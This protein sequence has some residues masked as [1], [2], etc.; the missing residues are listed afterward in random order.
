MLAITSCETA[1]KDLEWG[2]SRLYMPQATSGFYSVPLAGDPANQNYELD[3]LANTLEIYL[4]VYRSGSE[5][6]SSATAFIITETDT[7]NQLIAEGVISN[8]IL[9]PSDTYELPDKV[10]ISSGQQS[11]AFRLS[12]DLVKLNENYADLTGKKLVL[13]VGLDETS[14]IELNKD[15]STTIIIIDIER[16]LPLN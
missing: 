7:V 6:S 16:F 10:T 14:D 2:I 5:I 13:A 12:V 9:L 4:G 11:H 3:S 15:L 8:A 1:D